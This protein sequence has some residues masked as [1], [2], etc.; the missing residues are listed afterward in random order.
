[1]SAELKEKYFCKDMPK[2]FFDLLPSGTVRQKKFPSDSKH[3]AIWDFMLCKNE[4]D[5]YVALCGELSQ[6]LS[7]RLFHYDTLSGELK[8]IFD[9][10]EEFFVNP[11]EIPPSKIHTSLTELP[12][13]RILMTTHTTAR[14]PKHPYWLFDSMYEHIHEAYQGS[15][16][17]IYNPADGS[18]KNL[19]IPVKHDSIYGGCYDAKHNAFFCT[20]FLKG[21]LYRIDLNNMSVMNLG[22]TT[23]M[24]SYGVF[25]DNRNGIYTSSRSGHI[26]RIDIDTLEI[27]D[28]GI[29]GGE[30]EDLYNWDLHRLIAHWEV[31]KDGKCYFSMHFSDKLYCLDPDKESFEVAASL[32]PRGDWRNTPPQLQKGHA[33]DSN[34]VLWYM[35]VRESANCY[36]GGILHLFRYDFLNGKEPEFMGVVG[37][38]EM[39]AGT[40]C[41][42]G[43]D[44]NDILYVPSGNHGEDMSWMMALDLRQIYAKR[45]EAKEKSRDPWNYCS[46][47][48]GKDYY[49]LG[50][51]DKVT[52]KY[53]AFRKYMIEDSAWRSANAQSRVEFAECQAFKVWE[54]LESDSDHTIKNI[55]FV[56]DVVYA[57]VGGKTFKFE[58]GEYAETAEKIDFDAKVLPKFDSDIELPYR[59]GRKF[60][61]EATAAG[62]M[63]DGRYF[64]GSKDG[65]FS[66]V[67][68]ADGSVFAL[69]AVGAEG[70]VHDIAVSADG[71]VAYAVMGDADDLGHL[72][73]Y[74]GKRGLRDLGRVCKEIPH[75][76]ITSNTEL[77]CVAVNSDG[78]KVAVGG[79]GRLGS[80]FI[81]TFEK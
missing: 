4:R 31:G 35:V 1:M 33:F 32:A 15:H 28:L 12:D 68:V 26:W 30:A 81:Y 11:R 78:S 57:E 39:T 54:K 9:A 48:D 80:V 58:N 45:N 24:G 25:S 73:A 65:V 44:K 50:D 6:P 52:E 21:N 69:G 29:A 19:G 47:V 18:V 66:L 79:A 75:E 56:G 74:D 10:S 36:P 2:E 41:H 13:G 14:S 16:L 20:T 34:N 72:V 42:V 67:N 46:F 61:S 76:V 51:Y 71:L 63:A 23:E 37:D 27:K 49:P 7:V 70:E 59:A 60:L 43:I 64:V 77:S 55:K 17:I 53:F 8:F 38:T 62:V 3:N 40:V 22:Q 5:A